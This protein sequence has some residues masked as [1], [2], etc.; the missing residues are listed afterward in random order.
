[1][2]HE[3]HEYAQKVYEQVNLAS[4]D[5]FSICYVDPAVDIEYYNTPGKISA[6]NPAQSIQ[7]ICINAAHCIGPE[8]PWSEYVRSLPQ[9]REIIVVSE[10]NGI[11]D[12]QKWPLALLDVDWEKEP[13]DTNW[14]F[15]F[16]RFREH[17][18]DVKLRHPEWMAPWRGACTWREVLSHQ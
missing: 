17:F 15:R 8:V 16:H 2:C 10:D 18:E 13:D 11:F 12:D 4:P 7:R 9:L 3:S 5:H 6:S 14:R 1:V